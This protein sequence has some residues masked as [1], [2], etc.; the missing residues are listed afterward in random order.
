[1]VAELASCSRSAAMSDVEMGHASLAL[2]YTLPEGRPVWGVASLGDELFVVREG[3]SDVEV[4]RF[5]TLC[6]RLPVRRLAAA[7]D[8]AACNRHTCL[9][10]TDV[11]N[12]SNDGGGG[13]AAGPSPRYAI[14]RSV[15]PPAT[16]LTPLLP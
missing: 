3:A 13:T 9:Y 10:I 11:G 5:T 12:R 2:L 6:R 14:H 15:P 16:R 7:R 8:L 4:H 1:M